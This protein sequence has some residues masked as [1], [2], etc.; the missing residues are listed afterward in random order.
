M[1][2][3]DLP[4][5]I[6]RAQ[7]ECTKCFKSSASNGR[8]GTSIQGQMHEAQIPFYLYPMICD[9]LDYILAVNVTGTEFKTSCEVDA[10]RP[11]GRDSNQ[12]TMHVPTV[13]L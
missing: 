13:Y 8:F 6:P 9:L 1:E 3:P 7:R 12:A 2:A 5:E 4:Q 11:G 10:P